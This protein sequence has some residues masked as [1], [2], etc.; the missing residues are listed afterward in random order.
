MV[1]GQENINLSQ[2]TLSSKKLWAISTAC[3]L[4]ASAKA[5]VQLWVPPAFDLLLESTAVNPE[6]LR[7]QQHLVKKLQQS[8]DLD[9]QKVLSSLMAAGGGI[10][11]EAFI[12]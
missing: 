1:T 8:S 7:K 9:V 3:Y 10:D 12:E 2:L 6:R 11:H 4:R 5:D